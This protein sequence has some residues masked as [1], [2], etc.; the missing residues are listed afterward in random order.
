MLSPQTMTENVSAPQRAVKTVSGG[1][2]RADSISPRETPLLEVIST[3]PSGVNKTARTARGPRKK[4]WRRMAAANKT[5][6]AAAAAKRNGA[7]IVIISMIPA[8]AVA[9]PPDNK[10]AIRQEKE[11]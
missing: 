3:P 4:A 1:E 5:A 6:V 9:P 7:G 2:A 11:N 8:M 10:T